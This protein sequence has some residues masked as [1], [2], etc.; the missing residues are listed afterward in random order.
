MALLKNS[1][2]C[3]Q[4]CWGLGKALKLLTT[5]KH[6]ESSQRDRVLSV[7]K[8]NSTA[9]YITSKRAEHARR[10]HPT[11]GTGVRTAPGTRTALQCTGRDCTLRA[12]PV[13]A[14]PRGI[15]S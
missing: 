13:G 6:P 7:L 8:S 3:C 1:I 5:L 11:A 12:S 15:H 9:G 14:R 10:G 2:I 4:R